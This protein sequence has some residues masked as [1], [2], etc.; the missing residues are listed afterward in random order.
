MIKPDLHPDFKEFLD[1][2][3]AQRVRFVV[4]GAH[5][6]A[7]LGA[8]RY[9]TDLDVLVEATVANSKRL[10]K[11][12]EMFGFPELAAEAVEH[13]SKPERM[14]TI[15]RKPLQ[16]DILS[17]IAS[18]SFAAAWKGRVT[19]VVGGRRI[20]FL[21]RNE[22]RRVKRAVGRTKDLL[23]LALLDE[24]GPMKR[25]RARKTRA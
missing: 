14:A 12:F 16:I 5:A 20:A 1:C 9:T 17:S 4:V 24:V 13:F 25:S 10:A 11:A 6:L 8:A 22:M 23:D 3:S 2:L 19:V 7:V 18:V 15:G 21:G